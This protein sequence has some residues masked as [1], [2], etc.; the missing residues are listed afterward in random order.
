MFI[1]DR[2]ACT[3]DCGPGIRYAI[4]V[5]NQYT[6]GA[7]EVS[8][9]ELVSD[10]SKYPWLTGITLVGAVNH[11]H[12]ECVELMKKIPKHIKLRIE[13]FLPRKYFENCDL[14]KLATEIVYTTE[15]H[16]NIEEV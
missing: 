16:N 7:Y 15:R 10:I 8:V 6:E 14:A 9:D 3:L 1:L 12:N 5:S 2:Q 13:I 11:Q 4:N